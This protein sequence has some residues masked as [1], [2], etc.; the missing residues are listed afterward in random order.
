MILLLIGKDPLLPFNFSEKI[1]NKLVEAMR[2]TA[3]VCLLTGGLGYAGFKTAIM[4]M[5][6][7]KG[8][9]RITDL[10]N[11]FFLV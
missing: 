10:Q 3:V 4:M 1:K 5:W 2:Y 6:K 9:S 11:T 7:P 8:D